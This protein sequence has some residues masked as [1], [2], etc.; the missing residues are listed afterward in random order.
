[1]HH[2][3]LSTEFC[4]NMCSCFWENCVSTSENTLLISAFLEY[5]IQCLI[6]YKIGS[7]LVCNAS[8]CVEIIPCWITHYSICRPCMGNSVATTPRELILLHQ[9]LMSSKSRILLVLS[10]I[11]KSHIPSNFQPLACYRVGVPAVNARADIIRAT[12]WRNF[13]C[14]SFRVL[15]CWERV[16]KKLWSSH[17]QLPSPFARN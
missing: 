14:C 6:L 8:M 4:L 2:S 17:V 1:M 5:G 12:N 7:I 13:T 3:N 16:I 10:V 9:V 15:S 11:H